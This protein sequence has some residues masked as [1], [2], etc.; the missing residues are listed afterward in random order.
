MPLCLFGIAPGNR[1]R[2]PGL[3]PLPELAKPPYQHQLLTRRLPRPI[4]VFRLLKLWII[5]CKMPLFV[6]IV[7][8]DL[9]G[10]FLRL[11]ASIS[12]REA[13]RGI[14]YINSDD[15]VGAFLS[16]FPISLILFISPPAFLSIL[17]GLTFGGVSILG[18]L[19]S[20]GL[21]FLRPRTIFVGV[22]KLPWKLISLD[23]LVALRTAIVY[24][25]H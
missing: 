17:P 18:M 5:F 9:N 3:R 4:L 25:F 22:F 6:I 8:S 24:F 14:C 21:R 12:A 19:K 7:T 10:I 13:S 2:G 16:L 15:R 1:G 23:R 20:L 11:S